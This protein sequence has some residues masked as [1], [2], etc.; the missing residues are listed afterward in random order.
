MG[1]CCWHR[2]VLYS[3]TSHFAVLIALGSFFIGLF[4][5]Y[6]VLTLTSNSYFYL[7][8]NFQLLASSR[9]RRPSP[10]LTDVLLALL[11]LRRL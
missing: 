8:P 2:G 7:T 5:V 6:A 3:T 11:G 4:L 10:L 1:P 9:C